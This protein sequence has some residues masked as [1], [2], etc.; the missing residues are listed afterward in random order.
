MVPFATGMLY[1]GQTYIKYDSGREKKNPRG[2]D[3]WF[4][5]GVVGRNPGGRRAFKH[6]L[7]I[8][9]NFLFHHVKS[10]HELI[11][12]AILIVV[13]LLRKHLGERNG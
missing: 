12:F 4:E 5:M 6:F 1:E 10:L 7:S 13:A 11:S 3:K 2:S 8:I 9:V